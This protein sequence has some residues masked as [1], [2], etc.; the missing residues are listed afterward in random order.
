MRRVRALRVAFVVSFVLMAGCSLPAPAAPPDGVGDVPRVMAALGDS[1]TRAANPD[2]AAFGD[3]PEFSWATGAAGLMRNASHAERLRLLAEND[4]VITHNLARSGARVIDLPRQAGLAVEARAEYVTIMLGTNDACALGDESLFRDSLH[5]GLRLLRDGLP[6][7]A[8]VYVVSVPNLTALRNLSAEHPHLQRTWDATRIC[9]ALLSSESGDETR[10]E[11]G[12]LV[13]AYNAIL[14]QETA[15]FG[16]A[17]DGGIV[18]ATIFDV[19]DLSD[20]DFFHPSLSGQRRLADV[21][22]AAGPLAEV[23]RA[24]ISSAA[25][26]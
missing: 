3:H 13:D 24:K 22:W 7:G 10:A 26:P 1:I 8:V 18:H 5:E 11:V 20:L 15:S 17:F 16:V 4:S 14:A 12:R 25:A 23:E 9:P 19:S 6:A 2:G 21:T